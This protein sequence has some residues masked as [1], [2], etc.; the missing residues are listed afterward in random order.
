MFPRGGRRVLY[1]FIYVWGLKL[2]SHLVGSMSSEKPLKSTRVV[3]VADLSNA[4]MSGYCHGV[5]G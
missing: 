4:T 5:S 1:E 3:P 2:L